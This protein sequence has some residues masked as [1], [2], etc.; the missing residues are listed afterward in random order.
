MDPID[1]RKLRQ[2]TQESYLRTSSNKVR[3]DILIP[4]AELKLE[5]QQEFQEHEVEEKF[6]PVAELEDEPAFDENAMKNPLM[7]YIF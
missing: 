2:I 7:D 1:E 4:E 6:M 5:P 3:P